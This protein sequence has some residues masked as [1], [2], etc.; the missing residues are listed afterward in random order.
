MA[1]IS[2]YALTM[3]HWDGCSVSAALK[4]RSPGGLIVCNSMTF[5]LS[6][7]LELNMGMQMPS[8]DV[9]VC[10]TT[11]DTVTDWKRKSLHIRQVHSQT[12]QHLAKEHSTS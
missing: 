1:D 3:L 2:L 7:R 6:T 12:H 10:Q 11:V 9:P 5:R 4:D 8:P